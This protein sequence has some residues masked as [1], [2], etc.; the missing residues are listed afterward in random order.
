VVQG[1]I[2]VDCLARRL[3]WF[4]RTLQRR[5]TA[6]GLNYSDVLSDVRK[7][8][9]LNLLQNQSLCVAQIAYSLGYS[10]V[11]AFNHAFRR[12]VGKAPREYRS[13]QCRESQ[14]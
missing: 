9:A 1:D 14:G 13:S 4:T 3:G 5:L 6:L 12:W 11:S 10:D 2:G 7:R 8:L